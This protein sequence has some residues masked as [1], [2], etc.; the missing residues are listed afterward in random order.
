MSFRTVMIS[1]RC[2]L[3]LRMNYLEVRSDETKKILLDDIDTL[4][5][6]NPAVCITG[7]LLSALMDKKI[8]VV[9]C[10][11]KRN[12]Q[13]E[14]IPYH[15]SYD[16]SRK[17]KKQISWVESIK[18]EVWT[19]IVEDKIR[20]QAEFL[21]EIGST[22]ESELLFSY[23]EQLEYRDETNREGHAAK[24]YFNALFGMDFSRNDDNATNAALNYGYA[25]ILSAVNREVAALGY[26]TELGLFH[27]NLYNPY[28]LSC[29][30]MEPWRI[31][32]DRF[33]Y[34]QRFKK[35]EKEEKHKMLEVFQ[36]E[37]RIGDTKQVLPNGMRIYVRSIFDA[38]CEQDTSMLLF[39][40][41]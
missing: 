9:F 29:D 31:L 25:L 35:F 39:Y 1:S 28:N 22:R 38:L 40:K 32:V 6:E 33:V 34:E 13:G 5:I 17:L 41:V 11:N 37:I 12:P 26:H 21:Q 27:D 7:C 2:K 15:G 18:G 16:C 4:I 23:I 36:L 19:R 14:I 24:V 30:F 8:K 3:D 20:K 10:D